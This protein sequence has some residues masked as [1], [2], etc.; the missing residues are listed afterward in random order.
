VDEF[1]FGYTDR[2]EGLKEASCSAPNENVKGKERQLV[3]AIP[4][5]RIEYIKYRERV[6]WHK[7]QRVDLVFGTG[8]IAGDDG[9]RMKIDAVIA[10]YDEWLV[11]KEAS[12]QQSVTVSVD[13]GVLCDFDAGVRLLLA[14]PA[15][16]LAPKELWASLTSNPGAAAGTHFP[17][18][19]G[20]KVQI[21]TQLPQ[22]FL[23]LF[24]G[25]LAAKSCGPR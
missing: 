25:R 9:N 19:T 5:H 17:S 14:K 23:P 6:V 18:F 8:S 15:A 13:L 1:I 16:Q 24:R 12:K 7:A 4:E 2:F 11:E 22:P 21:L 20:I 10:S 3:K